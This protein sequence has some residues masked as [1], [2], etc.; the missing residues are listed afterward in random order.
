VTKLHWG[1]ERAILGFG[2]GNGKNS[3]IFTS[4]LVIILIKNFLG[5]YV[6]SFTILSHL[7][8][9]TI[10]MNLKSL[11]QCPFN[12]IKHNSFSE[13]AMELFS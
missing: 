2:K 8:L 12:E 11:V 6:S 13:H 9:I 4:L 5:I 3:F 7:T 10:I 1:R